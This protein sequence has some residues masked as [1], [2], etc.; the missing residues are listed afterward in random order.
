MARR[1]DLERL[2]RH[3]VA[4][5]SLAG[6]LVGRLVGALDVVRQ[7]LDGPWRAPA[8]LQLAASR[9]TA[10][11]AGATVRHLRTR[12]E[13]AFGYARA[14][15]L[16]RDQAAAREDLARAEAPPEARA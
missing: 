16:L 1:R 9:L 7:W 14:A 11:H 15:R 8:R 10:V 12:V 2:L 6:G 3:H 13:E 5:A 4:E